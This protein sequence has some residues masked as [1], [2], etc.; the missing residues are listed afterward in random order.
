MKNQETR[1]FGNERLK[2]DFFEV[3]SVD[4][5]DD[6][7]DIDGGL[8]ISCVVVVINGDDGETDKGFGVIG[9]GRGIENGVIGDGIENGPCCGE[10]NCVDKCSTIV[11][12]RINSCRDTSGEY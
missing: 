5:D 6:D 12:S 7:E 4:D 2:D 8:T 11:S 10:N 1:D 3:C 9:D